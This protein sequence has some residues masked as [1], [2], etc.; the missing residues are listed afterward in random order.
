MRRWL[1]VHTALHMGRVIESTDLWHRPEAVDTYPSL[2]WV[3]EETRS[4]M[5]PWD[6][7]L[8]DA[9]RRLVKAVEWPRYKPPAK[10]SLDDR[11]LQFTGTWPDIGEL[12]KFKPWYQGKS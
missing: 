2:R 1:L 3:H 12:A 6:Y 10:V 4:T 9:A 5:A 11:G 7:M 8:R